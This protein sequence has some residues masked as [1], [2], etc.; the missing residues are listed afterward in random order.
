MY[1][2]I[3]TCTYVH[4][5]SCQRDVKRFSRWQWKFTEVCQHIEF[6]AFIQV[7]KCVCFDFLSKN[8]FTKM[9]VFIIKFCRPITIILLFTDAHKQQ[10]QK[11]INQ[12]K[13]DTI[14]YYFVKMNQKSRLRPQLVQLGYTVRDMISHH[15]FW[16]KRVIFEVN[17]IFQLQWMLIKFR[18]FLG[19]IFSYK[20]LYCSTNNFTEEFKFQV[21]YGLLTES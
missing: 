14:D 4:I 20:N 16:Y 18:Q 11:F 21:R 3:H 10:R 7:C 5:I 17:R 13:V 8:N 9:L 2:H 15:I 1:I 12:L 19:A 6:I